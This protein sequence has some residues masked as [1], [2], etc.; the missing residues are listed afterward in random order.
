MPLVGVVGA[1][2]L[3]SMY[4][5]AIEDPS[6]V[7]LMRHRAVLFGILGVLLIA[8]SRVTAWQLGAMW[9]GLVSVI[10]FLVLAWST[11]GANAN[12][13]K[14]VAVDVVALVLLLVGL[15]AKLALARRR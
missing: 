7:V 5:V 11:D 12:I 15:A 1:D 10:S 2:Q 6:L 13:G 8:A 4:G 14:V 9:M 3:V